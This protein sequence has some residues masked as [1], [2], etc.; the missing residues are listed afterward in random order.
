MSVMKDIFEHLGF[1]EL[2]AEDLEILVRCRAAMLLLWP[3]T[4]PRR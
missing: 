4:P 3:V 2:S 1:D